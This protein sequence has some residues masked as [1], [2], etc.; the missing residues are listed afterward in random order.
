MDYWNALSD[1]E[2]A[3]AQEEWD[4]MTSS[5]HGL[6]AQGLARRYN[7]HY[8]AKRDREME[9]IAKKWPQFGLQADNSPA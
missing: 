4:R 6:Y 2:K 1:E 3:Q 8:R 5:P 9:Q 7:G